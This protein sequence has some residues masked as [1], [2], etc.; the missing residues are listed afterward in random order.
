MLA[1][2]GLGYLVNQA[3]PR[4]VADPQAATA[5][6]TRVEAISGD[7]ASLAL[8]VVCALAAG[9]FG[10]FVFRHWYRFHRLLNRGE[11]FIVHHPWFDIAMVLFSTAGIVL[12]RAR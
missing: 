7:Q 9:A 2:V 4:L 8:A 11:A 12:T 3:W 5:D 1:I 6:L 10:L